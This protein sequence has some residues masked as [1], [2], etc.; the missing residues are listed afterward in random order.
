MFGIS[1]SVTKITSSVGKGLSAATL[2]SDYQTK[3]RMTQRR[4]KPKHA[5]YGVAAGASAFAN[6]MTSAFEGVAVSAC[7]PLSDLTYKL[8]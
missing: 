1:D 5:L 4:N 2:D 6:S 3:R 7:P 8:D